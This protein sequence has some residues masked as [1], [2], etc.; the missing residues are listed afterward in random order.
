MG[1]IHILEEATAKLALEQLARASYYT[2]RSGEPVNSAICE[3]QTTIQELKRSSPTDKAL[4]K[5][6]HRIQ[7]SA[8]QNREE[9][10]EGFFI[11]Q[12]LDKRLEKESCRV[13]A[14]MKKVEMR[15]HLPDLDAEDRISQIQAVENHQLETGDRLW[16]YDYI[17]ASIWTGKMSV[18]EQLE[19]TTLFEP[20]EPFDDAAMMVSSDLPERSG[21]T[22]NVLSLDLL[23]CVP[24]VAGEVGM[25]WIGGQ[26]SQK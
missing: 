4:M 8:C 6:L 14:I 9:L 2:I 21:S 18:E 3:L 13:T 1:L 23:E 5:T 25:L 26:G 10:S 15:S 20:V 7:E 19:H 17:P 16:I 12:L 24:I 11:D 22:R